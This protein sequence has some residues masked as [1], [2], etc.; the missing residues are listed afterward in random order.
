[1]TE[2]TTNPKASTK[3][4]TAT[5]PKAATTAKETAPRFSLPFAVPK[6]DLSKVDL[7][8]VDL[9]K[10]DLSRFDPREIDV[11]AL[12]ST[13]KGAAVTAK[14]KATAVSIDVRKNI[15]HTVTLL[16]EAVGI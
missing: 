1:M 14:S 15:A 5:K 4:K 16:R 3:P 6:V 8:K 11:N 7:S 9:S 10:V 12:A 2:Q 13:A